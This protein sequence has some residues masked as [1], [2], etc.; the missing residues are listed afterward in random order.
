[1]II[2]I[3]IS[4]VGHEMNR[5]IKVFRERNPYFNG[6]VSL[7][8]HSLGSVICYDLLTHQTE[9]DL[10]EETTI[11]KKS[12]ENLSSSQSNDTETLESFL[13]RSDLSEFKDLFDKEK[14][15]MKSLV[16]KYS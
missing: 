12:S 11:D 16:N 5:L 2:K 7:I 10:E 13:K 14:I 3:I 4:K 6:K 15:S 9:N 1:M 8:G